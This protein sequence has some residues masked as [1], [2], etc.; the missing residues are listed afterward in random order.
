MSNNVHVT[1]NLKIWF[2][3]ILLVVTLPVGAASEQTDSTLEARDLYVQYLPDVELTNIMWRNIISTDGQLID[4]LKMATYEVHRSSTM[5]QPGFDRETTLIASDIPACN[6]TDSNEECS[7]KEHVLEYYPPPSKVNVRFIYYAIVTILRDGTVTDTVNLGI[8]QTPPG[9]VEDTAPIQS[10]Q[11]FTATY[12]ASNKSTHFSWRPACT[13]SNYDYI[14]YEHNEPATRSTWDEIEK[15]ITTDEIPQNVSEYTLD[16]TYESYYKPIEREIYYTLTCLY[17]PYCDDEACYPGSED[18]RFYTDNTLSEPIIEDTRVPRYSGHLLA[19]YDR[20]DSTTSLQWTKVAEKDIS[21]ILLYH[22][23]DPIVSVVQEN[24]TV[25]AEL[26][27]DSVEFVHHLTTDWMTTSYY[28]LGLVD[29]SGNVQTNNFDVLG[30]VGPVLERMLPISITSLDVEIENSTTLLFSWDIDS[31]F[32]QGDAVL[33]KSEVTTPDLSVEWTEVSR[34][35]PM[36]GEFYY[37]VIQLDTSWYA[38]TLEGTWGSST[39]THIDDRIEA[40]TNAIYLIPQW[41]SEDGTDESNFSSDE[42]IDLP[43]FE[44]T[45]LE[46]NQTVKNGD[47]ITLFAETNTTHEFS[48][49]S[50]QNGSTYRWS[51]ALNDDPFWFGA[52]SSSGI[53]T[54]TVENPIKLIHIESTNANGEVDIIRVGIDWNYHESN[55]PVE[56]EEPTT[57]DEKKSSSEEQTISPFLL[58]IIS[59]MVAYIVVLF[60]QSKPE[61][62]LFLE[63][64]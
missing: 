2:V 61:K 22:S 12:N 10:P 38:L 41:Q 26:P 16:W 62:Q 25:L 8:S 21:S 45:L 13:G 4:E 48:F 64:E 15:V 37:S 18:V 34:L 36:E 60:I 24:V 11:D 33:W 55:Q 6:S 35:N 52:T 7:G 51:N 1:M 56:E 9:Y 28:A 57:K 27:A 44:I 63:E 46:T 31:S 58:I 49:S 39:N 42:K 17:P 32:S 20:E 14:L 50:S 5:F 3:S 40:N 47:W 23:T 59:L 29:N 53:W 54:I 30:K 19:E 43:S